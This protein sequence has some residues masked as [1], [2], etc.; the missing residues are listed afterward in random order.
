ML[1]KFV[2][3]VI[4]CVFVDVDLV[5]N[6]FFKSVTQGCLTYTNKVSLFPA[7]F[8]ISRTTDCSFCPRFIVVI[9]FM[10]HSFLCT[11]SV[12]VC[13]SNLYCSFPPSVSASL[14]PPQTCP[15]RCNTLPLYFSF[16]A[17]KRSLGLQPAGLCVFFEWIPDEVGLGEWW[18]GLVFVCVCRADFVRALARIQPLT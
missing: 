16:S 15:S 13:P 9:D 8:H 3:Y 7:L 12:W 6:F 10:S 5:K 11:P 14:S 4:V 1:V 18:A 17:C 2:Y